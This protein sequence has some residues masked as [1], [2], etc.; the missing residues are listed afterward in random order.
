MRRPRAALRRARGQRAGRGTR[1]LRP[2]REQVVDLLPRVGACRR[3]TSRSGAPSPGITGVR[4]SCTRLVGLAGAGGQQL[5]RRRSARCETGAALMPVHE[6]ARAAARRRTEAQP[7]E[8]PPVQL[9]VLERRRE[10]ADARLER[11]EV[12]PERSAASSG[13]VSSTMPGR[14]Q[15]VAVAVAS[16]ERY[17]G[18]AL[19][20]GRPA[21][22]RR[23]AR[24]AV[25]AR[26]CGVAVGAGA[27]AGAS[28]A[29]ARRADGT[30]PS[31]QRAA[32]DRLPRV[33]RR[34]CSMPVLVAPS[35]SSSAIQSELSIG[36]A[37]ATAGAA[38]R[39]SG[40]VS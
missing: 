40:T 15:D 22:R 17:C 4:A 8:Q 5:A 20:S 13:S 7:G 16:S 25:E 30:T 31:A 21:A 38:A 9:R 19:R 10:V 11:V 12:R 39:S 18:Y 23:R 14:E 37:S 32:R 1:H 24:S 6:D 26:A 3:P 34:A 35:R 27:P 29:S 2:G 33:A 28:C 36:V